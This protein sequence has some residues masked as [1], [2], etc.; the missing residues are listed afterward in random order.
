MANESEVWQRLVADPAD[1]MMDDP[2]TPE[3][4]AFADRFLDAVKRFRWSA[5]VALHK[6]A[7][8]GFARVDFG[9]G[10]S[11]AHSPADKHYSLADK[12]YFKELSWS[13]EVED[14]EWAVSH[15]HGCDPYSSVWELIKAKM[16][17]EVNGGGPKNEWCIRFHL[18]PRRLVAIMESCRRGYING[19][20]DVARHDHDGRETEELGL[21]II[22][23][24]AHDASLTFEILRLKPEIVRGWHR[25]T[26]S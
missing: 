24:N 9:E 23:N 25:R 12:H 1:P 3:A 18:Q 10:G 13:C 4:I 14:S 2:N 11:G 26:P 21:W 15:V 17:V 22:K 6:L 5:S 20:E 16:E 8:T 7:M 19:I